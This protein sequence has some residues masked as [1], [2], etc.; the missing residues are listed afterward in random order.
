VRLPVTLAFLLTLVRIAGADEA[1]R[2]AEAATLCTQLDAARAAADKDALA[3]A[4]AKVVALHNALDDEGAR[5]RLQVAVGDVLDADALALSSR[6]TAA[7]VLAGLHDERVWVQ[8]KRQWPAVDTEAAT[9]VEVRVVVAAGKVASPASVD[10]LLDLM[11]RG[12]DPNLVETSVSALAGFGWAK[13]R[14]KVLDG[15]GSTIPLVESGGGGGGRG[16]KASPETA[17]LWRRLG[18]TLLASLNTL[19][20]RNELTLAAWTDLLK[21]HKR[22]LDDLFLRERE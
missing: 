4:L 1:Q 6:T 8:L 14:V 16:A 22:R 15:L 5:K 19:T 18:P 20:G 3:G 12:R 11:K 13:N 17:A 21:Q 2:V 7:D 9:A 10:D